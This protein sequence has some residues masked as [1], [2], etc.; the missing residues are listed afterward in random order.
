VIVKLA[1][2]S[3]LHDQRRRCLGSRP[4]GATAVS[5]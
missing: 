3:L 5:P 1:S 2:M 4:D